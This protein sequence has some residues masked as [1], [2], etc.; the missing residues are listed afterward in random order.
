MLK[1]IVGL[2]SGGASGLG[3]ATVERIVSQGGKAVICDLPTSQ[4]AQV[5]QELGENTIFCPVDVTSEED[6]KNAVNQTKEKFGKLN[7][8]VNCAGVGIAFKTYN[9]HKKVPH[10]LVDFSR[11]LNVNVSGTFNVIRLG[12]GLMGENE[13]NEDGFRGVIIN[14]SSIAAFDGQIGQAAYA[15]SKGAIVSMTLPLARDFSTQGIR[16]CTI[17]PG[18]FD[19]PLLSSLPDK[20]KAY[21]HKCVPHPQRFGKPEEYAMLV[22]SIIENPLL[23]GEVIRLDGALRMQP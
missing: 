2:V 3:R 9:F 23:N 10:S 22:Q 18:L 1:N 13:P 4:G 14:T 15:A 12:V 11:V 21:L 7:V 20:V 6:V 8:L 16:V 19:T 5:A 17:A